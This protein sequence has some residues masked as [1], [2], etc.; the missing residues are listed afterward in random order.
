MGQR[1]ARS[2][3]KTSLLHHA[4]E[5]IPIFSA[6]LAEVHQSLKPGERDG[7]IITAAS[8]AE[9]LDIHDRK[10]LVLALEHARK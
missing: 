5:Q 8:N 4:E 2:E 3:E 9:I 1:S 7:F 6:S 10:P